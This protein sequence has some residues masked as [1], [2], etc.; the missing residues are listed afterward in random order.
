M[1]IIT[2][3]IKLIMNKMPKLILSLPKLSVLFVLVV[4][5]FS[6]MPVTK[7]AA[8]IGISPALLTNQW[9]KPGMKFRQEIIIS[10][11]DPVSDLDVSVEADLGPANSW[12]TYEP[13]D[14][15][16]I[17]KGV[18]RYPMT[19]VLSIPADAALQNYSGYI[20]VKTSPKSEGVS[21]GVSVVQ[22]AR[23]D[24]NF[25]VT[26]QEYRELS[27]LAMSITDIQEGNEG[28]LKLT[29][30]N[31]GNVDTAPDLVE[32][33]ILDLNNNSL[34]TIQIRELALIPVSTRT[35]VLAKFKPSVAPGEY[36]AHVT[37]FQNGAILRED[38]LV[39]RQLGKATV[40]SPQ[41]K[42]DND[43][44]GR[45]FGENLLLNLSLLLFE[46]LIAVVVV[47]LALR[48]KKYPHEMLARIKVAVGIAFVLVAIIS[49]LL[50][51]SQ[52]L[53]IVLGQNT[54]R[55]SQA[56]NREVQGLSTKSAIV[57]YPLYA[58]PDGSSEVVYQAVEGEQ[59]S[60][61]EDQGDWLKVAIPD[62]GEGWL[63]RVNIK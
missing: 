55:A 17:S 23:V 60:V 38:N 36:F 29:V 49:L 63:S 26:N 53:G 8:G 39:F 41:I 1:V 12:L 14:K 9:L 27:V 11:S 18:K 62:G 6:A 42:V 25:T 35:D 20:R 13:S 54:S 10:Q 21:G 3:L 45:M 24:V 30:E 46:G 44:W 19:I 51:N 61:I 32:V 16:T 48:R 40:Y 28:E 56:I 34:Q 4:L 7:V 58:K 43:F 2:I 57:Y 37:V 31:L 33:E 15:F 50:L 22:G 52:P 5:L 59:F 47:V